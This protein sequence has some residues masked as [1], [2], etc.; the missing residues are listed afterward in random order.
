MYKHL[1]PIGEIVDKLTI[2]LLKLQNME[3][4]TE[5]DRAVLWFQADACVKIIWNNFKEEAKEHPATSMKSLCDLI[6]ELS[7]SQAKQWG[8]ENE[9]RKF[10]SKEAAYAARKQNNERIRI[11]N[12]IN[13]L[14]GG[15]RE[16]DSREMKEYEEN[17]E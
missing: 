3:N 1:Y 15:T 12:K 11:K 5:E 7:D 14:L 8:H 6:I 17:E 13:Q 4:I 9:I 16:V 10:P 2:I